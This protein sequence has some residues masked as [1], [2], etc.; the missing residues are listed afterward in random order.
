MSQSR[1]FIPLSKSTAPYFVGIDLGGTNIKMGVVDDLGQTLSYLTVPTQVKKGAENAAKRMGDAVR[2]VVREAGVKPSDVA[3]VGLGSPGTMDIPAGKLVVPANLPGWDHFPI[4]DR[5]AEHAKLPVTFAND[6]T[7]AAYGEFWI[8]SGKGLPSLV[9]LTLGTGIGCGIIVGELLLDG[10]HSHGGEFGHSIIDSSEDARICGCGR[11]GHLEAYAS[12]TAVTKRTADWLS[13]RR[14][15][16]ILDRVGSGEELSALMVAEEA[17]KGDEL[18]N[19]IILQT[20]RYLAIGIVNLMHTINPA[21]ILLGGAMTFGGSESPLG[22]K[23]L[24]QV[25]KEV[26]CRA[27]A[28][29]AEKTVLGFATLGSD[30]GYLGAA[31]IA[32]A[33]H[34]KLCF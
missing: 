18:A 28:V 29:P 2:K 27:Y 6:A 23:F 20:A 3:R 33:E 21:G 15:T 4:R 12:A 19:E 8:G 31:G 5:V 13:V 1:Q 32:R 30:A 17:E 16:S 11:R 24:A 26:K 10:E 9:L 22:R 7:A 14:P 25:R 34:R